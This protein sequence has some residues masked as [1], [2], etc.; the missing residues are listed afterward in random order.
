MEFP[1]KYT[2]EVIMNDD[3]EFLRHSDRLEY[4]YR[5]AEEANVPFEHVAALDKKFEMLQR[6]IYSPD[7]TERVPGLMRDIAAKI[8]LTS[9]QVWHEQQ[10]G[11]IGRPIVYQ[12]LD[13]LAR[14]RTHYEHEGKDVP[15]K[16]KTSRDLTHPDIQTPAE[17]Y[18]YKRYLFNPELKKISGRIVNPKDRIIKKNLAFEVKRKFKLEMRIADIISE[19]IKPVYR[20]AQ[21]DK[22]SANQN[23]TSLEVTAQR[24]LGQLNI[25]FS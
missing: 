14:L 3:L 4:L 17:V 18:V 9:G 25:P 20:H 24:R 7:G 10:I 12:D 19:I 2:W 13:Y 8:G 16:S 5:I 1:I 11:T 6:G 15:P 21:N 22:K 23:G